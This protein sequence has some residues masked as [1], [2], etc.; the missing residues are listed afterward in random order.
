LSAE[1][2]VRLKLSNQV[3][4]I[5]AHRNVQAE[6][7]SPSTASGQMKSNKVNCEFLRVELNTNGGL[8]RVHAETNVFAQQFRRSTNKNSHASLSAA[9]VF[10][11]FFTHTNDV[12][13]LIAERDVVIT[14]DDSTAKGQRATYTATN[15]LVEL[16]GEPT[17]ETPRFKVDQADAILYDRASG[18]FSMR[19]PDGRA[20]AP[21]NALNQTR[22]PGGR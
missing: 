17:L 16:T 13:E 2:F 14:S 22:V 9:S 1:D 3:E 5:T 4:H 6:Q 7:F 8:Q 12:R 18:K 20:R 10:A 11:D 19:N 15:S 21:T